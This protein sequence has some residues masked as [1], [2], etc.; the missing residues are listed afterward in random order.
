MSHRE[1]IDSHPVPVHC[2]PASE[3]LGH[4]VAHVGNSSLRDLNVEHMNKFQE[5]SK[6]GR[7][8]Q[9][10]LLYFCLFY[11]EGTTLQLHHY[12]KGSAISEKNDGASHKPLST[13]D[14][15][16]TSRSRSS[17]RNYGDDSRGWKIGIFPFLIGLIEVFA[18]R[19]IN[20]LQVWQQNPEI[21]RAEVSEELVLNR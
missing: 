16:F 2:Q 8:P 10:R 13:Y 15:C 17:D 11:P 18:R 3:T 4:C 5:C 1:I 7:A 20:P 14:T 6:K 9:N 12:L 21:R 19:H